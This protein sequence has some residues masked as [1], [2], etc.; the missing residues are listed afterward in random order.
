[1][2]RDF[3]VVVLGAG[4]AG[5]KAAVKAAYFGKRVALVERE[6]RFGGACGTGGLA[7]KILRESALQY[8]GAMRRLV[9]VLQPM[10]SMR[11]A[12]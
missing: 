8:R 5:E 12:T 2:R 10:P 6:A 4:P 9:D 1:M 11:S 3:D 7:S